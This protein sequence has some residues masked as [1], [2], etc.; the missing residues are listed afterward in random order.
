MCLDLGGWVFSRKFNGGFEA[1]RTR[2]SLA[3]KEAVDEGPWHSAAGGKESSRAYM[4]NPQ[5]SSRTTYHT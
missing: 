1:K 4:E 2:R 3:G 5:W